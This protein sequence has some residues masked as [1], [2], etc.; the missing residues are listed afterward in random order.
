MHSLKQTL[1][2]TD[3]IRFPPSDSSSEYQRNFSS[4][5]LTLY[6][7]I[8]LPLMLATFLA[9]WG[10][11]RWYRVRDGRKEVEGEGDKGEGD[12]MVEKV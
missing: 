12:G 5:A 7:A 9:A 1:M 3:I 2:S 4:Q 6:L 8:T 10:F 11:W